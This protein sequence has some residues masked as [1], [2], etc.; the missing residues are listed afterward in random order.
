[1]I[2]EMRACCYVFWLVALLK[3]SV[4][5]MLCLLSSDGWFFLIYDG[6]TATEAGLAAEVM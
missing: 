3:R 6:T 5:G 1:M 2:K 4:Y